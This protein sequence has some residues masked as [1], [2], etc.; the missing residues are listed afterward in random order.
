MRILKIKSIDHVEQHLHEESNRKDKPK[1][2][3]CKPLYDENYRGDQP[4]YNE[5]WYEGVIDCSK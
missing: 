5:K 2:Y 1:N 3:Y 4:S